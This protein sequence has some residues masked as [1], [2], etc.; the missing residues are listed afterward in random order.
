MPP[1]RRVA[2]L[3]RCEVDAAQLRA[4]SHL[5]LGEC[6]VAR[7]FGASAWHSRFDVADRSSPMHGKPAPICALNITQLKLLNKAKG[8]NLE[9]TSSAQSTLSWHST[10]HL[11]TAA[12][13]ATRVRQSRGK[14]ATTR[15]RATTGTH[16]CASL[17]STSSNEIGFET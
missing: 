15:H 5:R 4:S 16:Q 1:P 8:I 13:S 11:R 17:F 14:V 10:S 6:G 9:H 3:A 2:P 7:Q 12:H